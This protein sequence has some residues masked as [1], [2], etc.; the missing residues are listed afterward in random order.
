MDIAIALLGLVGAW[1]LLAGSIYQAV[2][3]LRAHELAVERLQELGAL[4]QTKQVSGWW[5]LVPPVKVY[6]ERRRA[7][8]QKEVYF[9]A[10]SVEEFEG[11]VS[12]LNK[13]AGWLCVALGGVM[14]AI[15]ETHQFCRDHHIGEILFALI[16]IT[17]A[18]LCILFAR[19]RV[20]SSDQ[21][22]AKKRGVNAGAPPRVSPGT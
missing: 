18:G 10:L 21:L 9:N 5:W 8:A 20:I 17:L 14:I 6:L 3:E 16:A 2:L 1:L 11:L 22:L 4:A 12:F 19:V 7:M 15:K 13:S